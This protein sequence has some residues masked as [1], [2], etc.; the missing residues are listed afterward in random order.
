M[1]KDPRYGAINVLWDAAP[2]VGNQQ[3][4]MN[5]QIDAEAHAGMAC[6]VHLIE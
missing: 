1:W 5:M 3:V 4:R 2:L 6:A